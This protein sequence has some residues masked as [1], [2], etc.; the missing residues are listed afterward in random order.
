MEALKGLWW[1]D[2]HHFWSTEVSWDPQ[3][4]PKAFTSAV[5]IWGAHRWTSRESI[6]IVG[7]DIELCVQEHLSGVKATT[8]TK[9]PCKVLKGMCEPPPQKIRNPPTFSVAENCSS[10]QASHCRAVLVFLGTRGREGA[11]DSGIR[12]MNGRGLS[13]TH[14][15]AVVPWE[16]YLVMLSLSFLILKKWA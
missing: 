7:L 2:G 1:T 5:L 9:I 11:T 14:L 15:L 16:S 3:C 6:N 4:P 13:F 10:S 8:T 12:W